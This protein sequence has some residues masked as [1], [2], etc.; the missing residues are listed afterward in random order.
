MSSD[1]IK[2]VIQEK[3]FKPENPS[4]T[5][6]AAPAGSGEGEGQPQAQPAPLP[7]P[8]A[9]AQAEF[10]KPTTL[11]EAL[12]GALGLPG[13]TARMAVGLPLAAAT[14][15]MGTVENI[16]HPPP[17]FANVPLISPETATA[18][19]KT[20]FP[21]TRLI[22][23]LQSL[24]PTTA[25]AVGQ[26]LV[27]K[28]G[29]IASGQTS[30][31]NLGLLLA[32]PLAPE[33]R[34]AEALLAGGFGAQ[35]ALQAPAQ[36]KAY[37]AE[38][39]PVKKAGIAFEM[40][41]GLGLP[42][43]AG[44][45]AAFRG[46]V[47]KSI[48]NLGP[49]KIPT[50]REPLPTDLER[51]AAEPPPIPQPEAPVA[52]ETVTPET[53][54]AL[55][56]PPVTEPPTA[57]APAAPVALTAETAPDVAASLGLEHGQPLFTSDIPEEAAQAPITFKDPRSGANFE[58]PPGATLE[59]VQAAKDASWEKFKPGSSPIEKVAISSENLRDVPQD[60]RAQH[61]VAEG[62]LAT[63]SHENLI[64]DNPEALMAMADDEGNTTGAQH[65]VFQD[66]AGNIWT[67]EE[68]AKEGFPIHSQ[69]LRKLE[70]RTAEIEKGDLWYQG[71]GPDGATSWV[72]SNLE[73]A[74]DYAK[75]RGAGGKVNVF[76]PEQVGES[77]FADADGNLMS[78]REYAK[79]QS[80]DTTIQ[81]LGREMKLPE[82]IKSIPIEAA[83]PSLAKEA[84]DQVHNDW[85]Q[86]TLPDLTAKPV[87][88]PRLTSQALGILPPGVPQ[89]IKAGQALG[90]AIR[91]VA[92]GIR[93][94][95]KF[96]DF[97]KALLKWSATNQRATG[98][99]FKTTRELRAS[100]PQAVRREAITNW[101][102]AGGDIAELKARAAASKNVKLRD[103]YL[104]ATQLTP[105][106]IALAGKIRQTYDVL[107]KRAQ[108]YG[109]TINELPDYVNQIWR[110]QP[111]KDFF[112]SSNRKLSE[113]IRFAKQRYYDSFFHGEQA[114]LTPETKDIGKLL[115]IYMNEV[116][117]AI[118]AK[119]FVAD[120]AGSKASD[121]RPLLAST[122]MVKTVTEDKGQTHLVLPEMKPADAQ[123]YK[124]LDGHPALKAW[125]WR[126]QDENGNP[127]M[128]QGDL[129]V[130]PEIYSHLKNVLGES[131]L[132]EW[133][134]S[135]NEN[136]LSAIGKKAV[137]FLL[138][139]VNQVGKA[140]LLGFLSP[141]HQVQE[142]THAV[143]HRVNPFGG[144]PK[145]DLTDPAQM[146][147]ASHGLMLLPD[148]ASQ[149][150]FREGLDGS[151]KNL[152]SNLIGK[153]GK[154]G[155]TI[156]GW[157][158]NYQDYLFHDYIPSLKF[159][160]YEHILPRNMERYADQ[161]K[162]GEVT[163]DQVKYLSAQ[164]ANAAYGHLNYADMG[165]NPTIQHLLQATL[166][167]P[168]FL[169]ARGR[170]VG[171][172]LKPSLAGRE[173][174]AALA[175]LAVTQYVL[176]RTLNKTLDD[177]YHWDEPFDVI[178]GNRRYSMRSVPADIAHAFSDTRR[179]VSG[180]LSPFLGRGLLEGL[181]GVNYRREPTT[182]AQALSDIITGM[183]PLTLQPATRGLSE[184]GRDN[185]VSPMEQLLGSLGLHVSR[186][187]PVS[188]VYSL[189][190]DWVNKH[191]SEYGIDKREAIYPIS[192]YQQLRYAL[193]D[194]DAEKAQT[195]YKKLMANDQIDENELGK[196][197]KM[198]LNHPFTGTKKTDA[199]FEQ[200]LNEKDRK[201]YDAAVERRSL[202]WDR[203]ENLR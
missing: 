152:L 158:D 197:F 139:D 172:A 81:T 43:F 173:Q 70:P 117:N 132:R 147:A 32:G 29:E 11:S 144:L 16:V 47:P 100:V 15:D 94:I 39:D 141:F 187:S 44:A 85:T 82:P 186:F 184:T 150:L 114:G 196:R 33:G 129:V 155:E 73:K 31:S 38:K 145:V 67:R 46:A 125:R 185:P 181:S 77:A 140:T 62:D 163:A 20:A 203:F 113:S 64:K 134:R 135:S 68:L 49:E 161:I 107:L 151:S 109:I 127:I 7:T 50:A 65:N 23:Q 178:V 71:V 156:K 165:R 87:P 61:I 124:T 25:G 195:E 166:L 164:Q 168:D 89:V 36:F 55:E 167:A 199:I 24:Y 103:G 174:L 121:G 91:S 13:A 106:E 143:G 93:N 115:P 183:I 86:A 101:I 198:S 4:P 48:E 118:S 189:S 34:A 21:S 170:F 110:R 5:V 40:L 74:E 26:E 75:R 63:T 72:T 138:D 35:A 142:G 171:Q 54:T 98:E 194:N 191:G 53:P 153:A 45:H 1:D 97:R 96:T 99:L 157:A 202:L 90:G 19:I 2:K 119:Q 126:G 14:G 136:P 69:E 58:V 84:T 52:P 128:V 177:D 159:K 92:S 28:T 160:T 80:E 175:T 17:E 95:A 83:K 148:R 131:A 66:K 41:V 179:F 112:A 6:V 200:S 192:K 120:L 57:E 59:D 76:T 108:S 8:S 18:A 130:H 22:D 27:K 169:E 111:I 146:D 176:A 37:Q 3:F 154:V 51:T 190:A 30:E 182:A 193:E 162:S 116:N 123:D 102:Q 88:E 9:E 105:D 12:S 10:N 42:A 180:R 56:T 201:I 60:Q 188:K 137:K 133:F 79:T 104:A 122:G 78:P 149:S